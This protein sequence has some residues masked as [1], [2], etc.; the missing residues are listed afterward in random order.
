[1][2][3]AIFG[4]YSLPASAFPGKSRPSGKRG[5]PA[6]LYGLQS[7]RGGVEQFPARTGTGERQSDSTGVARRHGA[8][9][10]QLEPDRADAGVG[11][12]AAGEGDAANGFEQHIGHGGERQPVLVRPPGM[13]TGA[14]G[15]Q[16]ELLFLDPVLPV[17][18]GAV[19]PVVQPLRRALQ[20]GDD[21]TRVGAPPRM[22]GLDD[23]PPGAAPVRGGVRELVEHAH[24]FAA[25]LVRHGRQF[26]Y[27]RRLFG[28]RR[29]AGDAD[30]AIDVVAPAPRQHAATAESAV[31]AENDLHLR[32][33]PAQPFR[34][35]GQNRPGVPG[36]VAVAR[37][38]PGRRQ[39]VFAE[40]VQGRKAVAVA[41]SVEET[42]FPHA[43]RR[44]VGGVEVQHQTA[45]RAREGSDKPF[46]QHLVQ[47]HRTAPSRP[48][49]CSKRHRVEAPAS[50][51][52]ASTAVCGAGVDAR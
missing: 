22:P 39:P 1:M 45:G 49:P 20:T 9:L 29:I 33:G 24:L 40:H 8:D 10:Q 3:T 5:L 25:G 42:A 16:V 50:V 51:P 7:G 44:I 11:E 13:A 2:F 38:Q 48:I 36:A 34:Q 35:Q 14:V 43:A 18:S 21:I 4:Q 6:R 23:R 26:H 46:H 32:P 37:T 17:A 41:I 47:A 31:A 15:E 30:D 28:Q 12:F 52:S 19:D 27:G